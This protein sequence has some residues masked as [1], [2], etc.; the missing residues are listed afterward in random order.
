MHI[1]LCQIYTCH[2][3]RV[4]L[5]SYLHAEDVTVKSVTNVLYKFNARLGALFWKLKGP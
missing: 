1:Y 2:F 5:A 3:K 4:G